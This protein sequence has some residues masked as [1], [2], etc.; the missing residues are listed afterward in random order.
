MYRWFSYVVLD[1]QGQNTTGAVISRKALAQEIFFLKT[2][3]QHDDCSFKPSA[4]PAFSVFPNVFH[5]VD[6]PLGSVRVCLNLEFATLALPNGVMTLRKVTS[7][8]PSPKPE[9]M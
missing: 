3:A 8:I 2:C 4:A 7:K 6:I 1:A 5:P 9:S